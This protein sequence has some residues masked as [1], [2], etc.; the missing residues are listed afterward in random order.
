MEDFFYRKKHVEWQLFWVHNRTSM[1]DT[2]QNLVLH[3]WFFFFF[4]GFVSFGGSVFN[5]KTIN[6]HTQKVTGRI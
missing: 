5:L 1:S 3:N 2:N 6:H 4:K